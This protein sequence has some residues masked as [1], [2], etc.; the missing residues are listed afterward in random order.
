MVGEL[1]VDQQT[2]LAVIAE[3]PSVVIVAPVVTF[4]GPIPVT[5]V[6]FIS[7]EDA[8]NVEKVI[9]GP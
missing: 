2:P 8:E 9:C 1:V 6:V 7:I 5:A 3:P 4:F